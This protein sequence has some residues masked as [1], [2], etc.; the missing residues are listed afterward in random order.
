MSRSFVFLRKIFHINLLVWVSSLL[1]DRE[2]LLFI[3]SFLF[4]IV[5]LCHHSFQTKPKQSINNILT[6]IFSLFS[7]LFS[8]FSFRF[9]LSLFLSL[10]SF[11]FF[12][13]LI[14]E[15]KITPP[16]VGFVF[17]LRNKKDVL[18]VLS[19]ENAASM[20]KKTCLNLKNNLKEIEHADLGTLFV[21][22]IPG[23][24]FRQK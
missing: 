10:F 24:C 5:Y 18:S 14:H 11:L 13:Y 23:K 6:Y 19:K 8:L 9:S 3:H 2:Q 21:P 20:F 4:D 16:G 7:F 1:N 22:V 12:Y 17:F 15:G